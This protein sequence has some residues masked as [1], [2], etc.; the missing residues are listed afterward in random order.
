MCV[1]SLHNPYIWLSFSFMYDNQNVPRPL[2]FDTSLFFL[3][4]HRSGACELFW[5][6]FSRHCS[7]ILLKCL[8]GVCIFWP[9]FA[10]DIAPNWRKNKKEN[11]FYLFQVNWIMLSLLRHTLTKISKRIN[12]TMEWELARC[13]KHVTC[14]LIEQSWHSTGCSRSWC[15]WMKNENGN[16]VVERQRSR[17]G[18]QVRIFHVPHTENDARI[19]ISCI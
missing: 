11:R 1:Y 3:N 9:C 5:L 12:W 14:T 10:D 19:F 7:F 16:K 4:F 2:R 8:C 13:L 17:N 15:I 6:S 18:T